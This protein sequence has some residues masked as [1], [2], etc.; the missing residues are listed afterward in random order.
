MAGIS[1]VDLPFQPKQDEETVIKPD[2]SGPLVGRVFRTRIDPFV[3]KLNFMRIYSGT[4]KRDDH[5]AASSARKG[6]KDGVH[7][8]R[9][10]EKKQKPVESA[11]PGD[12][13]AVAKMDDLHT[14]TVLGEVE[15]DPI[16]FPTP[17]VG[18]RGIAEESWR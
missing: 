17:M 6:I 14:G 1:P 8:S 9:F 13:V 12:I 5:V 7:C 10:R 3:Q 2:S 15:M 18:S 16:K 4:L 11:G